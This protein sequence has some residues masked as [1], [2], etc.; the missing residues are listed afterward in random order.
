MAKYKVDTQEEEYYVEADSSNKARKEIMKVEKITMEKVELE[1]VGD[2]TGNFIFLEQDDPRWTEKK[3]GGSNSSVGRYG[4][5]VTCLSML[6]YW[7]GEYFNPGEIAEKANFTT[8]G[9]YYWKSGDEFLPFN[10]VWRY[11]KRDIVKIKQIL[12]SKDNAC[13]VRVNYAGAYHWLAVIGYDKKTGKLLGADP[14]DGSSSYIEIE[15][16]QINGFAEISRK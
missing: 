7:Y 10:F 12:F 2:T 15:Y 1:D 13:V 3:L 14:I 8:K 9:Y 6:S 5:L 16:G 11:Y 4:C